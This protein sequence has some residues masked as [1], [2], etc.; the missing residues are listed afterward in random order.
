MGPGVFFE[1]EEEQNVNSIVCQDQILFRLLKDFW[2]EAFGDVQKPI[3]V[4]DNASVHKKV[5]IPV[6][7][8]LGMRCH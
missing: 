7:Q 8:G 1:L 5:C 6:R 2:E 3:V 4:K